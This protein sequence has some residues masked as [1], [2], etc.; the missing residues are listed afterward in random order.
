[1]LEVPLST[2]ASTS[3]GSSASSALSLN[4]PGAVAVFS[5][6]SEVTESAPIS[7]ANDGL[8]FLVETE[9]QV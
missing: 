1:M 9:R 3:S 6:V 2:W 5:P 8:G 4:V 7:L